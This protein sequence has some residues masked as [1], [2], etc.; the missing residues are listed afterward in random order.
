MH[1]GLYVQ[2]VWYY[3]NDL[4]DTYIDK[5]IVF[6]LWPQLVRDDKMSEASFNSGISSSQSMQWVT[7]LKHAL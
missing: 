5:Y 2:Y 3:A 7:L 6:K 1:R 4:R